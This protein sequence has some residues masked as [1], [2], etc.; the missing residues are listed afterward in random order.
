MAEVCAHTVKR[1][2]WRYQRSLP[3][4]VWDAAVLEGNPFTY[5]DVQTL[6]DGVTVGG[7]KVS[8][9]EQVLNL[10]EAAFLASCHPD[11]DPEIRY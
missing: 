5:P 9:A 6:M 8:D 3:T 2:V 11:L 4:F 1:A 7:H 10:A